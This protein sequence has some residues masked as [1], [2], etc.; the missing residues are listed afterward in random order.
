MHFQVAIDEFG[1]ATQKAEGW[2][3]VALPDQHASSLVAKAPGLLGGGLTAFHGKEFTRK[4][5]ARFREFLVLLKE[6]CRGEEG[7]LIACTLNDEVW[8]AEFTGFA[9]RTMEGS[10]RGAGIV[11]DDAKTGMLR[12]VVSPLFT[13]Q[14]VS[15]RLGG[16]HTASIVLDEGRTTKGF[17][18]ATVDVKGVSFTLPHL[19]GMLYRAYRTQQF[20]SSPVVPR[21]EIRTARDDDS[22]LVQAADV[23][24]NFSSAY[25]FHRLG[26]RTKAN[27]LKAKIFE[28]VFGEFGVASIDHQASVEIEGDDLKLK[29]GGG[30]TFVLS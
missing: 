1:T 27:D 15:A 11:L 9:E 25:L 12:K 17:N 2:T 30:Y 21:D 20:P 8:Q 24:G 7:G 23:V 18:E 16:N 29:S 4:S 13:F 28:D 19:A 10:F 26:K 3:L 14:R 6:S 5:E 22:F